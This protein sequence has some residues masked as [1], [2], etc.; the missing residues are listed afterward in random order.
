VPQRGKTI[1]FS[2]AGCFCPY[3][4]RP[5]IQAEGTETH[6][7]SLPHAIPDSAMLLHV[8]D[9]LTTQRKYAGSLSGS[10][11]SPHQR[12]R[13]INV[14]RS[15]VNITIILHS[16]HSFHLWAELTCTSPD[17]PIRPFAHSP[18]RSFAV[19][20]IHRIVSLPSAFRFISLRICCRIPS[21]RHK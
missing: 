21:S 13:G 8:L 14:V 1:F 2:K 7:T 17:A 9:E 18:T 5:P 15:N 6:A 20:P 10:G 3:R 11:A 12:C 16:C 19:S 4:T